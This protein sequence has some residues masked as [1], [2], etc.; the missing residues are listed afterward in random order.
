MISLR[1][2]SKAF[3]LERRN[4][5]GTLALE[6][7]SL[8]VANGE[9]LTIVG[10]SGC[11][12][13]TVLSL[14]AGFEHPTSGEVFCNEQLVE[15]PGS[16]KVV[17]FQ[18]AGLYPWLN[19]RQN[20][21]LGLRLRD[22]KVDWQVVHD[23]VAKVGLTGFERHY[24]NELSGGMRQRVAL[25]RALIVNPEILL[26]DE[27][28]G[29]LDA[30]TRLA[31]QEQLLD[32]W[33]TIKATVVFVTHD[34]D[35]AILLGDRIAVMTPPPGR[36]AELVQVPFGRPR[37]LEMTLTPQFVELKRHVLGQLLGPNEIERLHSA[38]G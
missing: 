29:A 14:I 35:E 23:Y 1:K 25:A 19:V 17:V 2:V 24:P 10:P 31:M 6:D 27:P 34:V 30:Q 18:D 20:V 4:R 5:A 21:G 37:S 32:L 11:G 3:T 36:I 12:K 13:S 38:S 33:G 7:I 8:E 15:A 28:F 16:G 22:G 26:M 9:F